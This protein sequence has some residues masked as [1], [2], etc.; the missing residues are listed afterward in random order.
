MGAQIWLCCQHLLA[1]P[2]P[3]NREAFTLLSSFTPLLLP[4]QTPQDMDPLPAVA[5]FR[6]RE[7]PSFWAAL[8]AALVDED[9]LTRK[10]GRFLLRK[11]LPGRG[12]PGP[13]AGGGGRSE[14][15]KKGD[16]T[17]GG[18][19][20]KGKAGVKKRRET[21]ANEE[22]ARGMREWEG[23][24]VGRWEALLLLLETMEEYGVHLA[25]NAWP[26][27]IDILIPSVPPP[28]RRE[29]EGSDVD[30]SWLAVLFQ[31]GFEHNNPQ[32]K[33]KGGA[34]PTQP[35]PLLFF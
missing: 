31:R 7:D 27:Q 18:H 4:P 20:I 32:G 1:H 21:W 17:W 8:K 28:G 24:G 19:S 11:A 3:Q 14:A 13:G 29:G 22:E 16:A 6:L 25:E 5:P 15:E 33:G 12:A 35:P 9:S 2:A 30:F 23:E 10:R 26:M 34:L